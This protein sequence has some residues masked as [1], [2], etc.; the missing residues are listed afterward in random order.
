MSSVWM[1]TSI[2]ASA[3]VSLSAAKLSVYCTHNEIAGREK[4]GTLST[5]KSCGDVCTCY[6]FELL[7]LER[8]ATATNFE[9]LSK[10]YDYSQSC[11]TCICNSNPNLWATTE[12]I[13]NG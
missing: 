5:Y 12:R 2:V 9:L 3:L 4:Y 1:I 13:N 11:T 10:S 8:D 7:C 6:A